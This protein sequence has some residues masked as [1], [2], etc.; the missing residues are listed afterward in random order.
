MCVCGCAC[1]CVCVCACVCPYS[2]S[3][4]PIFSVLASFTQRMSIQSACIQQQVNLIC[5]LFPALLLYIL[6]FRRPSA[7]KTLAGSSRRINFHYSGI[8]TPGLNGIVG[9]WPVRDNKLLTFHFSGIRALGLDG[10]VGW[11]PDH[12]STISFFGVYTILLDILGFD[13]II[14]QYLQYFRFGKKCA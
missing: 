14:T 3:R 1:T 10:I 4:V 13:T 7:V 6:G 8:C 11:W 5:L 9:W 2:Y 12:P